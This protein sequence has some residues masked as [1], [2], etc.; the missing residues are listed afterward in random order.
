MKD[1][2]A[3]QEKE[4]RHPDFD[5]YVPLPYLSVDT[6]G[7][8]LKGN[9]A[10]ESFFGYPPWKLQDI[11]IWDLCAEE[12]RLRVKDLFARLKRGFSLESEEVVF[13]R[14]DGAEVYSLFSVSP[15]KDASGEVV[16]GRVIIV[17]VSRLK[18]IGERLVADNEMWEKSFGAVK[19]GLFI[20]D[21]DHRIMRANPAMEALVGKKGEDLIGRDCY[22]VVHNTSFPPE[23]CVA[24]AALDS[25]D[26]SHAEV[27][28]PNLGKYIEVEANPVY[29]AGGE[30]KYVVHLI[31]DITE[32]KRAEEEL[33]RINEELEAYARMVSHDLKGPISIIISSVAALGELEKGHQDGGESEQCGEIMEIIGRSA[34]NAAGLIDDLLSLAQVGQVSQEIADVDVADVVR[35]VLEERSGLI[36][37]KGIVVAMDEDLGRV[38]ADPT[39]IYQLFSNLIVNALTHNDSPS[40]EVRIEYRGKD[41]DGGLNYAVV[42]NGSGFSPT[43]V[44]G[45]FEPFYIGEGGGAGLGLAIAKRIIDVYQGDIR[46]YANDGACFEFTLRELP[47]E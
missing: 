46:A 4:V 8:V 24:C 16:G 39:H 11:S 43:D 35:R 29:G 1:A 40:P 14:K 18:E 7:Q 27:Y 21:V 13:R 32:R 22:E 5:E 38:S 6:E 36:D 20:I 23:G 28:E 45:L 2:D 41:E 30:V 15:L 3:K 17:D 31:R 25:G 47:G 19:E 33:K 34:R 26:R 12:S 44:N 10:A 42:D 9:R 37:E